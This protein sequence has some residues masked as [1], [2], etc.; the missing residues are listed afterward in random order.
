MAMLAKQFQ[1]AEAGKPT[2]PCKTSKSNRPQKKCN[3]ESTT[4]KIQSLLIT[5]VCCML[6]EDIFDI[7]S[8]H[9]SIIS[10]HTI[11]I[12]IMTLLRNQAILLDHNELDEA[13]AMYQ[14]MV[15][16]AK[17]FGTVFSHFAQVVELSGNGTWMMLG[18]FGIF[19]LVALHR[20]VEH[21]G[22]NRLHCNHS[23]NLKGV[24]FHSFI[25]TPVGPVGNKSR[26]PQHG[27]THPNSLW[28]IVN[29]RM[30]PQTFFFPSEIA[31]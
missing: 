11:G 9:A 24:V 20:E 12:V 31:F 26:S 2:D 21:N 17:W 25:K 14:E 3:H 5:D 19:W 30:K 18:I 6:K 15:N 7:L 8:S 1:R 28:R 16:S 27:K 22:T 10:R 29:F 4:T 23:L 13:L